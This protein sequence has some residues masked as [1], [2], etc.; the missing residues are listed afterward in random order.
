MKN[1]IAL[2]LLPVAT[3]ASAHDSTL[4]HVHPHRIGILPDLGAMTLAALL[5][6]ITVV[7]IRNRR[8]VK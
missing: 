6:A 5:V 3:V 2:M 4:S 1:L 7:V 8:R